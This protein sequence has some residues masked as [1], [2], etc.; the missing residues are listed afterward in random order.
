[1]TYD[2]VFKSYEDTKKVRKENGVKVTRYDVSD[3]NGYKKL[4]EDYLIRKAK[5]KKIA[6]NINRIG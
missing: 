1:M 6:I 3:K 4:K 2:M 5:K